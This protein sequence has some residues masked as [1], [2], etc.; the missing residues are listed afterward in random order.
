MCCPMLYYKKRLQQFKQ[1]PGMVRAYLRC[2]NE[3]L[4]SHSES[5]TAKR[6]PDVYEYFVTNAFFDNYRDYAKAN[7]GGGIF[8]DKP[9]YKKLIEDYFKIEL[10]DLD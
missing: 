3:Y 8:S 1:W 10:P 6:H 5:K 2:G 4:K 9:D 7:L